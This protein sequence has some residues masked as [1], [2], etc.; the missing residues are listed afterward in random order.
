MET[1]FDILLLFSGG[2]DSTLLLEL[3]RNMGKKVLCFI[4]DYGQ[5]HRKELEFA[6]RY[7]DSKNVPYIMTDISLPIASNLT[8]DKRTYEGVSPYHVPARN[9]MFVSMAAS[10]AESRNIPTIWFGANYEDREHLFPDC[11]QEW[12]YKLNQLLEI[13]GS[14]KIKVEAPL[15]GMSKDTIIGMADTL[16]ITKNQ[17]FSGYGKQ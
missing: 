4:L 17:I 7:C 5:D 16:G 14:M 6:I 9:L 15:L 8:E 1:K 12:V 2:Y 3:A 10:I 11:Y 13:N